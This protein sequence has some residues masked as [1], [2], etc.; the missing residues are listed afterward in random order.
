MLAYASW[1]LRRDGAAVVAAP[2]CPPTGTAPLTAV[3]TALPQIQAV[4]VNNTGGS[5]SS[6]SDGSGRA[7]LARVRTT[8]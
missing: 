7:H 3:P 8:S 5:G 1:P 2:S 4:R 6:G